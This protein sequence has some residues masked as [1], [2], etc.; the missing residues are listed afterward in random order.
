[1]A[2]DLNALLALPH[3][4]RM[5]L[6][7]TLLESAA[8]PELGALLRDLA[9]GLERTNHALELAIARLSA[10]DERLQRSRAEVREAVL[11]SGEA[12]PFPGR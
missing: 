7:E 9:S 11:L 10:F 1:M 12:W 4:E 2:A 6:A 5:K 8:P 3:D